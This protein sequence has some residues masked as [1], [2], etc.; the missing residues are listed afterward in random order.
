VSTKQCHNWRYLFFGKTIGGTLDLKVIGDLRLALVGASG[1]FTVYNIAWLIVHITISS[2][3]TL[4]SQ[5][6]LR[7]LQI[8]VASSTC[9]QAAEVASHLW[10]QSKLG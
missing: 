2:H 7:W 6:Y 9:W 10:F 8:R 4:H 1:G 5:S 3:V